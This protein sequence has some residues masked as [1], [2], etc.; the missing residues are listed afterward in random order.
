MR[1]D[2]TGPTYSDPTTITLEPDEVDLISDL[3]H[4]FALGTLD[5]GTWTDL[6]RDQA[7]RI[8]EALIEFTQDN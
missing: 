8:S 5:L 1:I 6:D 7:L 2:Q 4:R 3:L